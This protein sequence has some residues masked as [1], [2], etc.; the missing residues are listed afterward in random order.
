[1]S[2]SDNSPI[3]F[4]TGSPSPTVQS[5]R[6]P[7]SGFRPGAGAAHPDHRS[8][9]SSGAGSS[10]KSM[11]IRLHRSGLSPSRPWPVP[12]TIAS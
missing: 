4:S 11:I 6:V 12:G 7:G 8:A 10:R 2:R 1:M 9:G 5:T 3:G